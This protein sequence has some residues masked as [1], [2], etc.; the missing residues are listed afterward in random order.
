[1]ETRLF[2]CLSHNVVERIEWGN[3]CE[4]ALYRL[5]KYIQIFYLGFCFLDFKTLLT[6][7]IY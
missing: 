6:E 1:M 4:S 3:M 7:D 2:F 5:S